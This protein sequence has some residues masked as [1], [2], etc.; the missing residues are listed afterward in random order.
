MVDKGKSVEA[1]FSYI[2][3]TLGTHE[4]FYIFVIKKYDLKTNFLLVGEA[5]NPKVYFEKPHVN[6]KPTVLGVETSDEV[7]LRNDDTTDFAFKIIKESLHSAGHL[8]QI[9]VQP[10][11][12][13]L[14]PHS[15]MS[16]RFQALHK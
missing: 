10:M 4:A 9:T 16:L 12:G 2:P 11:K 6:L 14:N 1:I 7:V 5:R 8:Q 3:Q 13:H 15:A